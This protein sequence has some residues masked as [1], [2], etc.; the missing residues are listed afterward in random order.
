VHTTDL[1]RTS[2]HVRKSANKRLMQ[3]DGRRSGIHASRAQFI[4]SQAREGWFSNFY[5]VFSKTRR[6]LCIPLSAQLGIIRHVEMT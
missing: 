3:C 5:F 2:L 4:V 6:L 1:G